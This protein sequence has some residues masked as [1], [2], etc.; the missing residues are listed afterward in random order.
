MSTLD[1]TFRALADPTRRAILSRLAVGELTVGELSA[2][3]TISLPAISRHLRVL[4]EASLIACERDGK[5]RRCQLNPQGLRGAAEWI[6]V[7]RRFWSESFDR[8]EEHLKRRKSRRR[9]RHD[10]GAD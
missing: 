6:E 5:F 8:L 10:I 4:E 1:A 3:F 7:Y 9:K 2:P